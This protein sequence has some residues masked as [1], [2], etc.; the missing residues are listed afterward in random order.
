MISLDGEALK[1]HC[2]FVLNPTTQY[3]TDRNLRARQ[4]LWD[5]LTPPFDLVSWVIGLLRVP[6]GGTVLDA[7]CG[8]GRYLGH[9]RDRGA[10][11]VGCD[12]SPGMLRCAS[13]PAVV[14]AD[15]TDLP[16]AAGTFDRV[17]AA[18]MLYHVEDR[19]AAVGEL[20]RV[21]ADGGVCVAVTNGAAHAESIRILVERAVHPSD[22]DWQMSDSRLRRAFS[23]ENG[24]AQMRLAFD[25]VRIVRPA[26]ESKVM[27]R[28]PDVVAA[29]VAS[30]GDHY[31]SELSCRWSDVV[32]EVRSAVRNVI[33]NE[34]VF[35]T[36]SDAGALICQ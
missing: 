23:L 3:V 28:D 11:V 2:G 30:L 31:E 35:T 27:V 12:R 22:P 20:R 13:E 1:R 29:Y 14:M 21:L 34:G 24:A 36:M 16:F 6:P 7:G 15:V 26:H 17:L 32:D 18:H 33:E 9:I 8:N 19:P 10:T 4:R 5:H 25:E